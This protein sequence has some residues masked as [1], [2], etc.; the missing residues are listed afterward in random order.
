VLEI[1]LAEVLQDKQSEAVF[2][3][4]KQGYTQTAHSYPVS[5]YPLIHVQSDVDFLKAVVTQVSHVSLV[6]LQV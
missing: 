5:K 2:T 6:V 3:Q 1:L 4:V